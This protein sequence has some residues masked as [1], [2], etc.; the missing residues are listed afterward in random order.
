MS[1]MKNE[2]VEKQTRG[3]CALANL[4]G[5]GADLAEEGGLLA[6]VDAMQQHGESAV[7]LLFLTPKPTRTVFARANQ[8]RGNMDTLR[9]LVALVIDHCSS[10]DLEAATEA[11]K[12]AAF[13][14]LLLVI[15]KELPDGA[16]EHC[17]SGVVQGLKALQTLAGTSAGNLAALTAALQQNSRYAR[18]KGHRYAADEQVK[19]QLTALERAL[20]AAR[21]PSDHEPLQ[22]KQMITDLR[23]AGV[24]SKRSRD[25]GGL[26]PASLDPAS[27]T[28]RGDKGNNG[29]RGGKGCRANGTK[30]K[31][32]RFVTFG[33]SPI[34]S[35]LTQASLPT[36]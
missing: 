33:L 35:N 9:Q 34:R 28:L 11:Q 3:C 22:S 16:E 17:T 4:A 21:A 29:G 25:S 20:N 19:A 1:E 32:V 5:V 8:A 18:L 23:A 10:K 2:D 15:E 7:H 30:A 27:K 6:L 12:E 26:D 14:Q 13:E 31:T 24:A 36:S